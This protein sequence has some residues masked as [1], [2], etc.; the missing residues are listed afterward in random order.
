MAD[1]QQ[2]V[3]TLLN[4]LTESGGERGLQV[5]AYVGGECVVDAWS[6]SADPDSG[7]VVDGDTLF[8]VFSVGKGIAATAVHILAARGLLDYDEP[9]CRYWPEFR[10][11]GKAA[12][13]VRQVL[14]HTAGI[15]QLPDGVTIAD[16]CEWDR[17]CAAIAQL[18]PLW[19]PGTRMGYHATTWGFLVSELIHRADGR[20]FQQVVADEICRPL[21]IRTLFFGI[22]EATESCVA[23]LEAVEPSAAATS[24]APDSLL[25]RVMGPVPRTPAIW[26]RPDIRRACIPAAGGI[27]NARAIARHYA[28]LIDTVNGIRLLS[29]DR[30]RAATA[31]QMEGN[32]VV[33]GR[34]ATRALGYG[35]GGPL[36]GMGNRRTAFGHAG[37]GGAIGFADPE[38]HFAF[39]LT[40]NHLVTSSPGEGS[41]VAVARVVRN[42][43]GIPEE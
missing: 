1:P 25:P 27:M 33:L 9:V 13:T 26:N 29:P 20:P 14:T 2:Q 6:G 22:P 16:V 15:P 19:Q 41:A 30:L 28:A 23:Q 40:K 8:T 12:I 32:D 34:P 31:L 37:T 39:A 35:L 11:N 42:A 7:R 10:V 38:Y 17:I 5:V 4:E 43:L 24:L 18:E 36:A 3:Q 21:D